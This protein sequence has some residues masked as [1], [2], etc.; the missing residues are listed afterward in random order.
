M[1]LSALFTAFRMLAFAQITVTSLTFPVA[2]DTLRYALDDAPPTTLN[3]N[4]S[5]GGAQTWDFSG[6]IATETFQVAYRPASAGTYKNSFP[7]AE[8]VVI[9]GA[10]ETYFNATNMRFE[11]MGFSG[12]FPG[13]FGAN[14]L[15]RYN[16]FLI[17]RRSPMNF[18][19][20]NVTGS[21][22]SFAFST[23]LLPDSLFMGFPAP[24][25]IRIR[26]NT[27]RTDAVDGWGTCIIPPSGATYD[28][29]REKRTEYSTTA[30]DIYV[31]NPFPLGWVDLSTFF[32]GG[33]GFAGL[34]GTDTTINYVFLSNTEKEEIAVASYDASGAQL[35]TV[36][37]KFAGTTSTHTGGAPGKAN[38][39]AH[40]N[41]AVDWVRFDCTNLPSDSYTFK[42][43][44]IVGNVVWKETHFLSGDRSVR[45][46]LD[47]FK[48]GTYLYS[49][50]DKAGNTIATKRLVIIK[51]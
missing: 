22:L 13:A 39:Q 47:N 41:P 30:I 25:S 11:T 46:D 42:I 28:V 8:M 4:S 10:S 40:P 26:I 14:V 1:L 3:A 19:D 20:I 49:L 12:A 18:F 44:D 33:G 38:I 16:P 2:G 45:V 51:P 48:K 9:E 24:D 43:F 37:F 27:F 21:D 6:L 23:D 5:P 32:P 29:L 36:Q 34:I 15:G 7:G 35:N 31:S 17:E 50:E